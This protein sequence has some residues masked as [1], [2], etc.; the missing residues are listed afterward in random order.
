MADF[1]DDSLLRALK[2]WSLEE[3]IDRATADRTTFHW[4]QQLTN[5]ESSLLGVLEN[6]ATG[7][8]EISVTTNIATHRGPVILTGS[9]FFALDLQNRILLIAVRAVSNIS[10]EAA[11]RTTLASPPNNGSKPSLAEALALAAGDRPRMRV[12]T[13]WNTEVRAGDLVAVGTD[14]IALDQAGPPR[15]TTMIPIDQLAEISFR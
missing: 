9:D 15:L 5:D 2:A 8:T 7:H 1:D 10:L 4:Q 14:L 13:I 3:R 11:W 6:A 12:G